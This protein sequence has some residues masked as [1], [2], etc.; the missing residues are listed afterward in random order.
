MSESP[1]FDVSSVTSISN[2]PH[3][4]LNLSHFYVKN[5][6]DFF[7]L[8]FFYLLLLTV[9]VFQTISS[10]RRFRSEISHPW[11]EINN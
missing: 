3:K 4:Y 8:P 5:I 2:F 6:L 9:T 11:L 1:Y 7:A 10:A